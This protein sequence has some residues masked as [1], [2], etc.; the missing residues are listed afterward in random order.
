EEVWTHLGQAGVGVT[1]RD[2]QVGHQRPERIGPQPVEAFPVFGEP[3]PTLLL[4]QL[5]E[6]GDAVAREALEVADQS[7]HG[8]IVT[9]DRAPS[10]ASAGRHLGS[11]RRLASIASAT[12]SNGLP[13]GVGLGT[14]LKPRRSASAPS[15]AWRGAAASSSPCTY[16]PATAPSALT[17]PSVW[18]IR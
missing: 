15:K 18:S 1:D 7:A 4:L 8:R 16:V 9:V 13:V 11:S 3:G 5:E 12:R 2:R 14:K 17:A 10:A 6:E